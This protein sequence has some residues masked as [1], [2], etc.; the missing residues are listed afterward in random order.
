MSRCRAPRT[1][2]CVSRGDAGL[3]DGPLPLADEGEDLAGDVAF[4]A[5]DDLFL[6]QAFFGTPLHVGASTGFPA[7]TAQCDAVEGGVGLSVAAAVEPVP[8]GVAAAARIRA[9]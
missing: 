8:D 1:P 4:E 9:P 3:I 6:G 2:F 5:A 7:Q